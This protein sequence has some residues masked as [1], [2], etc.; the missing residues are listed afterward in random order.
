MLKRN[1][2]TPE[3][4]NLINDSTRIQGIIESNESL[5]IDGTVEGDIRCSARLVIGK[6]AHIQGN[7]VC[8]H[9]ELLGNISGDVLAE[10]SCTLRATAVLKGNLNAA[11]LSVE[12]G[13]QF[14]G[15]CTMLDA[16][17]VEQ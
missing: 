4:P 16:K 1:S 13:A 6:N 5:R 11:L 12:N 14:H 2:S 8:Q 10:N 15:K 17:S 9:L 7:I 3:S